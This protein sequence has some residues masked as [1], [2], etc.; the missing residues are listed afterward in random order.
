MTATNNY[1]LADD[2]RS[3]LC[4]LLRDTPFADS[5]TVTPRRK[6]QY[7]ARR[8]RRAMRRRAM[9][10]IAPIGVTQQGNFVVVDSGE[11]LPSRHMGFLVEGV[12]PDGT[13]WGRFVDS[14]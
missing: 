7:L 9:W 3:L 14:D 11:E 12:H 2:M 6:R 8:S 13:V 10:G 4:Y 1:V 5:V